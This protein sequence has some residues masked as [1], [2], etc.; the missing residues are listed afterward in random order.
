LI[1]G[2]IWESDTKSLI[3]KY[4]DKN[5]KKVDYKKFPGIEV[6]CYQN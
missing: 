1:L 3:K 6:I 4:F 2:R 5:Y